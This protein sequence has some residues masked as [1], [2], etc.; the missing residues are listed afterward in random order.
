MGDINIML[1]ANFEFYQNMFSESHILLKLVNV[2][3]SIFSVFS[4]DLCKIW[5]SLDPTCSK[6]AAFFIP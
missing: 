3:F 1:L 6:L 5:Y 4:S 2:I